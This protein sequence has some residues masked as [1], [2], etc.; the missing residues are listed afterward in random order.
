MVIDL[1]FR[2]GPFKA[3]KKTFSTNPIVQQIREKI[4]LALTTLKTKVTCFWI[5]LHVGIRENK[6]ADEAVK[7]VVR[8]TISHLPIPDEDLHS[9]L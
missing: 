5:P 9:I 1:S 4:Y 3:E 6:E 8:N 7:S 2:L